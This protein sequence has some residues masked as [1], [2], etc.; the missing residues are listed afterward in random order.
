M[1]SYG[2]TKLF[3]LYNNWLRHPRYD[4]SAILQLTCTEIMEKLRPALIKIHGTGRGHIE[5]IDGSSFASIRADSGGA[6][7]GH[8]G[9]AYGLNDWGFRDSAVTSPK[10]RQQPN[11]TRVWTL[12]CA[13]NH[14]TEQQHQGQEQWRSQKWSLN[15][16][17]KYSNRWADL[18]QL[19]LH[20]WRICFHQF[21]Y[22]SLSSLCY[23]FDTP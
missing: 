21:G 20:A 12:K 22:K 15:S 1:V 4:L 11:S 7:A 5:T 23:A 3:T 6:P 18:C 8:D 10:R 9:S 17:L 13:T 14:L 19:I 2:Q 16:C